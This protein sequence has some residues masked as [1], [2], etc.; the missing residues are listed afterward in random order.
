MQH[1]IVPTQV[2][3]PLRIAI[4]GMGGA[5][6]VFRH[7]PER[8]IGRALVRR[9]H[10]VVNIGYHDPRIPALAATEEQVDGILVRRV[11]V[12]HW[13]TRQLH[14]ALTASGPFDV[15]YLL[16]PRNVLAWGAT[17]WAKQR[18]V[19][20]VYTWLGPLHDR[21]LVRDRER[22]Y[23]E[24]PSYER[25]IWS[26]PQLLR[27]VRRDGRLR[28]HLRNYALHWP[29]AV[30]DAFVPVSRHEAEALRR[31]GWPQPQ[32]LLP[33]WLD[34]EAIWATPRRPIALPRPALLFI[35]Q[36]TP[37]KGYDLLVRALPRVAQRYPGV[38]LQV[39]SGLNQEDRRR[40]EALARELGVWERI[41]LRGRVEDAELIN[42]YRSVDVYVTPT[43]YEGFGLTLLEAMAA[44]CPLIAS[45]IPVVNEIVTH[46]VNGWLARY[47]DPDDLAC[48][49]LRLLEDEALRQ[50]LVAGGA[51][52]IA[53]RFREE[54]LVARLEALMYSLQTHRVPRERGG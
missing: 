5:T 20:T 52:T 49:I 24:Q 1:A 29:L 50:R 17:R 54:Q 27:R 2:R 51:Q 44:G 11:P 39:V 13:P 21:Y 53:E 6:R 28:D 23:D 38:S 34:F 45:D 41:V 18:G 9:G 26:V 19:P 30:A 22:P 8:V 32:T 36:L 46:T 47:D 15:L 12:Q 16:H 35:G 40:L 33:L 48:A 4:V 43:R 25:L 3:A 42:L 10:T 31:A 7:W 37:R 14:A